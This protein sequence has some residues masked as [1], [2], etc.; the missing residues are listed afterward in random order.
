MWDVERENTWGKWYYVRKE[1]K[2]QNRSI[3]KY[4]K[5]KKLLWKRRKKANEMKTHL[6]RS[7]RCGWEGKGRK[8]NEN[9]S[10]SL[11]AL[12]ASVLFVTHFYYVL[13]VKRNTDLERKVKWKIEKLLSRHWKYLMSVV[14]CR[15]LR[16]WEN[17][18]NLTLWKFK[19]IVSTFRIFILLKEIRALIKA[20]TLQLFLVTDNGGLW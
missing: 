5:V 12:L 11:Y 13:H 8:E 14:A 18:I 16:E 1:V 9:M 4:V 2:Y 6:I 17:L 7:R 20:R 3:K 19:W 15:E 10:I